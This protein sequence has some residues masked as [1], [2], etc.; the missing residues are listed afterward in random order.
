MSVQRESPPRRPASPPPDLLEDEVDL[1]RYWASVAA[2]WWLPLLGLVLGAIVG[3]L[4]AL[5]GGSTYRAQA[6]VSLGTPLAVGGGILPSVQTNT[7]AVRQI[8]A[9]ESTK[10]RVARDT[11]LRPGQMTVSAT[12]AAGGTTAKGVPNT[13]FAITVKAPS[14]RKAALAANE[15]AR[16]VVQTI[17]D[18]YVNP[19]I[20]TLNAQVKADEAELASLDKRLGEEQALLGSLSGAEKLAA[21]GIIGIAEQ[22]RSVVTADLLSTKPLLQQA[23]SVE[24]GRILTRA[25]GTKTTARSKRNSAVV[26]AFLGLLLGIAAAL[27]WEPLTGR[28]PRRPAL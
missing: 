28:L 13:L 14:P 9:A 23:K 11:G 27:L 12:P 5:G 8:V 6:V 22:R 21:I 24:R 17:S 2:R 10:Q 7:A 19:K 1:G 16:I 4:I 3:Y 26:G 15:F 25:V 18:Q 20:A